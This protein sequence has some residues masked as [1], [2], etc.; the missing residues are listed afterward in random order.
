M[1]TRNR[2]LDQGFGFLAVLAFWALFFLAVHSITADIAG[3]WVTDP[4]AAAKAQQAAPELPDQRP[5]SV[6]PGPSTHPSALPP[7]L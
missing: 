7:R 1:S 4:V 2:H 6:G 5:S 3:E